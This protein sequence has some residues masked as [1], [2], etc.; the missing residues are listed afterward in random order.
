MVIAIQLM[1]Q[2]GALALEKQVTQT[3]NNLIAKN[4]EL[5]KQGSLEVAKSLETSIID[6]A[7]L[8]KNSENL[9]ET[10]KGIQQIR[11][12]GKASRL[13]APRELAVL[14]EKLNEQI[15]LSSGTQA[16]NDFNRRLSG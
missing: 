2:K 14:Q 4:S 3:T 5:L 1:R 8:Q 10:L 7:V 12:E 16:T 6:I 9:I 13:K 15:L 11:E